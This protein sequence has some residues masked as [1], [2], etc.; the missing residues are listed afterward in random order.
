M[1]DNPCLSRN[2]TADY[3]NNQ[4]YKQVSSIATNYGRLKNEFKMWQ[5]AETEIANGC[6]AGSLTCGI[7]GAIIDVQNSLVY[8][9]YYRTGYSCSSGY[10]LINN[11]TCEYR[12]N[13]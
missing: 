8:C 10:S 4:C 7:G 3:P 13:F 2:L 11:S 1:L 12:E 5:G 6:R 9:Y